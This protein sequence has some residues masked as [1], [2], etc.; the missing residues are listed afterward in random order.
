MALDRRRLVAM[1]V[2]EL[3][4]LMIDEHED[5]VL[6]RQQ[7][8]ESDFAVVMCVSS[9]RDELT[10]KKRR[11]RLCS[12][13]ATLPLGLNGSAFIFSAISPYCVRSNDAYSPRP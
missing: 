5:A 8:V 9:R 10:H 2:R 11:A 1:A 7:R 12:I 4:R 3:E 6:V 13:D